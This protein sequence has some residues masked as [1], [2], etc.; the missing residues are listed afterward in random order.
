MHIISGTIVLALVSIALLQFPM[1]GVAETTVYRWFNES[2]GVVFGD[3][4]RPGAA[5]IRIPDP[6]VYTPPSLP[7]GTTDPSPESTP[8]YQCL[9]LAEPQ[10]QSTIWSNQGDFQIRY[11]LTPR[12]RTDLDHRLVISLDG[13]ARPPIAGN[14]F[15][16]ENIDRGAHQLRGKVVNAAGDVLIESDAATIYLQQ[17]STHYPAR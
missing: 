2:G 11:A 17:Q 16:V 5:E 9:T 4:P 13:K 8:A 3:S 15:H 1:P 14:R 7:T 10:P 6:P 12:L